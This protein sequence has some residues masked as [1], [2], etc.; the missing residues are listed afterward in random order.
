MILATMPHPPTSTLQV[1]D[2]AVDPE[3]LLTI[4]A[5][6]PTFTPTDV[7]FQTYP[8]VDPTTKVQAEPA[9]TLPGALNYLI[10]LEMTDN[11]TPPDPNSPDAFLPTSNGNWTDGTNPSTDSPSSFGTMVLGRKNFLEKYFLP[12]LWKVNRVMIADLTSITPWIHQTHAAF[13]Y[14]YNFKYTMAVGSGVADVNSPDPDDSKYAFVRGAGPQDDSKYLE[15]KLDAKYGALPA[16]ALTWYF[17]SGVKRDN[18]DESGTWGSKSY[19]S[20]D[21]WSKSFSIRL[22]SWMKRLTD[23]SFSLESHQD[24]C[25]SWN[26]PIRHRRCSQYPIMLGSE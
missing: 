20:T 23:F 3:C 2:T 14:E 22:H 18:G 4:K 15:A 12:K 6:P 16:G 5:H 9:L 11:E 13:A 17:T 1:G 24:A 19:M 7:R 25:R 21:C 26:E 8:W 10:Y